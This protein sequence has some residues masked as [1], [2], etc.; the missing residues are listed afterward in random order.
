[1]LQNGDSIQALWEGTW[2]PALVNK[3]WHTPSA[4]YVT[5]YYARNTDAYPEHSEHVDYARVVDDG[6]ALEVHDE[7]GN[8]FQIP[9]RPAAVPLSFTPRELDALL[10]QEMEDYGEEAHADAYYTL[11]NLPFH[12]LQYMADGVHRYVAKQKAALM[13]SRGDAT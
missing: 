12:T 13:S 5:L 6:A 7:V 11:H 4:T 9:C 10:T 1:M 3:V 2:W 8:A